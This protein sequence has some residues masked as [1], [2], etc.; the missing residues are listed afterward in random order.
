MKK[1]LRNYLKTHTIVLGLRFLGMIFL[2]V[3]VVSCQTSSKA[4]HRKTKKK[5][6]DCDCPSFTQVRVVNP[7]IYDDKGT[8]FN[9]EKSGAFIA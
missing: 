9:R 8:E 1:P 2:F 4:Q 3:W 6:G 7:M 5:S